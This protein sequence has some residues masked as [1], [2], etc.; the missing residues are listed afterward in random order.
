[1]DGIKRMAIVTGGSYGI[2]K[3]CAA[4]LAESG[5]DIAILSRKR[6][7]GLETIEEISKFGTKVIHIETDVS[8]KEQVRRSV[9][10]VSDEFRRVDI[11]VNNAGIVTPVKYFFEQADE[12]WDRVIKVNLYGTFYMMKEVVPMMIKQ[13]YGRIVNITSV[14]A[15]SGSCGRANYVASK[16]AVELLT[17]TAAMELGEYGITVNVVRPGLTLTPLSIA[18]GYDFS[19]VAKGIPRQRIG[20]PKDVARIVHFLVQEE[21]DYITGQTFSGDG[22]IGLCG[23]GLMHALAPLKPKGT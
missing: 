4:V 15:R 21:S 6:K 2:G 7:E 9:A 16:S 19:G 18:R 12:D 17:M 1:M 8:D 5:M 3:A 22:G 10:Q 23:T 14:L 20:T 13:R 11:L